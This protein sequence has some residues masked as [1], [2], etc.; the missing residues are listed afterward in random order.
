[1]STALQYAYGPKVIAR[2]TLESKIRLLFVHSYSG[3]F[4]IGI[5]HKEKEKGSKKG[6]KVLLQKGQYKEGG[7]SGERDSMAS[8]WLVTPRKRVKKQVFKW[9]N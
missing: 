4:T 6:K 7:G 8:S 3:R 9:Y 1:M 2:S 5:Q